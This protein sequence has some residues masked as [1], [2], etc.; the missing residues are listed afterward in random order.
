MSNAIEFNNYLNILGFNLEY[1]H[2]KKCTLPFNYT[3]DYITD[4]I[5][6]WEIKTS[7][8]K[9]KIKSILNVFYN[10][11]NEKKTEIYKYRDINYFYNNKQLILF[12][13]APRT[14]NTFELYYIVLTKYTGYL[15]KIEQANIIVKHHILNYENLN[16]YTFHYIELNFT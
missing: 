5:S 14:N 10:Y 2:Q 15:V 7:I 1:S 11:T 6:M 8:N 4:Y 16:T 9:E 3:N 12:Y 13:S